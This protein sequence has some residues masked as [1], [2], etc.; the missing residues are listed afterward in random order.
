MDF[1]HLV[2]CICFISVLTISSSLQLLET[3]RNDKF[4]CKKV[5]VTGGIVHYKL[6]LTAGNESSIYRRQWYLTTKN[7]QNTYGIESCSPRLSNWFCSKWE[8]HDTYNGNCKRDSSFVVCKMGIAL[9]EETSTNPKI[10][11]FFIK[12]N[13]THV[14]KRKIHWRNCACTST[15]FRPN[16]DISNFSM[17]GNADVNIEL[18]NSK[19]PEVSD[20]DLSIIPKS[21]IT[22]NQYRKK[23][24]YK[25]SGFAIC[26][27]YKIS[28]TFKTKPICNNLKINP[29]SV[30]FPIR[31]I[32][33]D[34]SCCLYN[35][36]H[37]MITMNS[38]I[39]SEFYVSI[40]L[41]NKTFH[42]NFT[43][44]LTIS[45]KELEAHIFQNFAA[46]ISLCTRS[47]ENVESND[48]LFVTLKILLRHQIMQKATG[49]VSLGF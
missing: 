27:T 11:A 48:H 5:S 34:E 17:P 47:A 42:G 7:E 16:I 35:Q 36:S 21:G 4:D 26:Q 30:E 45:T 15:S 13:S 31:Q 12:Y 29:L 38:V 41:L 6:T 14:W 28:A 32:N 25:V 20:I 18:P 10:Y 39:Q 19:F 9:S 44:T 46:D 8:T 3:V 33:R 22:I 49:F 40:N 43:S 2:Y 1:P 37:I 23:Y 24:R